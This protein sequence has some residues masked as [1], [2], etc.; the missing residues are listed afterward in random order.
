[1]S[2]STQFVRF[3]ITYNTKFG[4]EILISGNDDSLGAWKTENAFK[5]TYNEGLWYGIVQVSSNAT[6]EYKYFVTSSTGPCWEAGKNRVINL[7]TLPPGDVLVEDNWKAEESPEEGYLYASVFKDIFKHPHTPLKLTAVPN[8]SILVRF[9]VNTALVR[10]EESVHL[11]GEIPALG[12][13]NP[14]K[15]IPLAYNSAGFFHVDVPIPASVNSFPFEYKFV[16]KD[17]TGTI[18]R[19]EE[20]NNRRVEL[21]KKLHFKSVIQSTVFRQ[22]KY[23]WRG[24]GVAVPV[25]SL[26]SSNG[27][28]VGEFSDLKLVVDFCAKIGCKLIQILPVNDTSCTGTWK[29]SYPYSALSVFA[30]HP[31][32]LH[33]PGITSV[34]SIL[35]KAKKAASGLNKLPEIDYEEVMK[36]KL[37][38][39]EEAFAADTTTLKCTEF[40]NFYAENSDWLLPYAVFRHFANKFNTTNY[41]DWP[42]EYQKLS[43][44]QIAQ[45]AEKHKSEMNLTFYT[46]YHLHV[47]L[48]EASKYAEKK[49]V[50]IKGDL[51]IGVNPRSVDSW[52]HPELFNLTMSTGAPPDQF[53][54]DGQNWGFPTYNWERMKQDNYSWWKRRLTQM[55]KYFQAFRIDHLLGFFRIWEI[56]RDF[57]SGL[58]GHFY[59]S[60]PIHKGELDS[61]GIWD[62]ERLTTPYI[63]WD[64]IQHNFGHNASYI[65]E[66]YLD[67]RADGNFNLKPH[68]DTETKIKKYM[69]NVKST[70]EGRPGVEH[71]KHVFSEWVKNVVLL[72]EKEQPQQH[73]YPRINMDKTSSFQHLPHNWKHMLQELYN[74]FYFRRQDDKWGKIGIERLPVIKGATNMLV[75]GEDLGMIPDCVFPVM[76]RLS[77]LGL[78]VQRMPPDPKKV[79]GHP[80]DYEYMTVC[81]TSSHDCSTLRGWWEED[82]EKTQKF[83]SE[84]LGERG[85]APQFCEPWIARKIVEQHLYSP[86]MWAIFPIQDFFAIHPPLRVENP[87][88]EQIN[89]PSNPT[90]YWRYRMHMT[91]EELSGTKDFMDDLKNLI[92]RSGRN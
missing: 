42:A 1:M 13:W 70:P 57:S 35:Q 27:L 18:S 69:D 68:L 22:S 9:C 65:V 28:G 77:I 81:T 64:D 29:D 14:T 5:L 83:F 60:I 36:T 74:D 46:Q 6:L 3:H 8:D 25:F 24:A 79:F 73:F 34:S 54:A 31:L 76:K 58:M 88:S 2:R 7:D 71:M 91:L 55:A 66:N 11:V 39:I 43:N 10:P 51:P 56:P 30:L 15:S 16:V 47:Q 63:H 45:L 78:R 72:R 32:Y 38:L 84:I 12:E 92:L 49:G 41:T 40:Q 19:W 87:K 67:K 82:R 89:E 26:R 86:S 61:R 44:T 59:P 62:I 4:E 21:P 80:S 37:S 17:P 75:C 53:S 52:L 90:H 85:S 23:D 33:I 20:G 48:K 50:G